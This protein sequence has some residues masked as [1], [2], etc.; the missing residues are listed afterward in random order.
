VISL[1]Q[2]RAMGVECFASEVYLGAKGA[3]GGREVSQIGIEPGAHELCDLVCRNLHVALGYALVQGGR[4]RGQYRG[5]G[6]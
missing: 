2:G 1:V 6:A 5:R 4:P 3:E